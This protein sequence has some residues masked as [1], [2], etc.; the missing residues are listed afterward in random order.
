ME[1]DKNKYTSNAEQS[2]QEHKRS[3]H[4][5]RPRK[6][7]LQPHWM[8]ER[9]SLVLFAYDRSRNLGNK[10]S[11]AIIEAVSFVREQNA[12]IAISE[13]EVKRILARWRSKDGKLTLIVTAPAPGCETKTL[14]NGRILRVKFKVS[15]GPCPIY[16]RINSSSMR[17]RNRPTLETPRPSLI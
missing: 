2:T 14:P 5:G 8:L 15:L 4:R 11:T 16:P 10:H 7:G 17:D 13:S 3:K 12:R 1:R 9:V 6:H